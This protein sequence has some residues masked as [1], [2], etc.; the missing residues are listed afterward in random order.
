M[1]PL[2][3]GLLLLALPLAT[4][5][6]PVSDGETASRF[7]L[8]GKLEV[9]EP[10]LAQGRFE[11]RGQ[12]APGARRSAQSLV[13]FSLKAALVPKGGALCFGPGHIFYDGFEGG[14]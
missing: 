4:L 14:P 2:R 6:T 10:T 5:A 7:E 13:G 9:V 11:L 1:V 3:L 8:R 12:L